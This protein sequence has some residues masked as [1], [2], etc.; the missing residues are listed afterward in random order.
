MA[1]ILIETDLDVVSKQ[2]LLV[3]EALWHD[4]VYIRIKET[5][6]DL[7]VSIKAYI[8]QYKYL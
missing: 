2:R 1:T 3:E 7:Y 6:I 4:S 5:L 8:V